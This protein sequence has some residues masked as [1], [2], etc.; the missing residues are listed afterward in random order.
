MPNNIKSERTRLGLT[1]EEFASRLSV[2]ERT[3]SDWER[4]KRDVP[5]RY[6]VMMSAM[7]GCSID[8]LFSLTDERIPTK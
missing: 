7:F 2:S 4:A 8:Y 3:V 1:Q 5:S 6:A